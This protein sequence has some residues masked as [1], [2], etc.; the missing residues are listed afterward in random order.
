MSVQQMVVVLEI[1]SICSFSKRILIQSSRGDNKCTY[2]IVIT[3]LPGSL[4]V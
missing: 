2:K 3:I 1:E 4:A